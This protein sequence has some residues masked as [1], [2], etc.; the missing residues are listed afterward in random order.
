M[1][2]EKIITA[3]KDRPTPFYYY[4]LDLLRSTLDIV[5]GESKKHN[6]KIHYAV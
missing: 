2:S 4:D 5:S 3:V 1:F 6:Y